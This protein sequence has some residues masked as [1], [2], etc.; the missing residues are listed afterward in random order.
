MRAIVVIE[1]K[2]VI[3]LTDQDLAD[4]LADTDGFSIDPQRLMELA[5]KWRGR[6][7]EDM[8]CSVRFAQ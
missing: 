3:E 8:T 2:Q 5:V 4:L 7:I 1:T 6:G